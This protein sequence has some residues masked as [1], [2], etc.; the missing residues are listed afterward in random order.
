MIGPMH[1]KSGTDMGKYCS[2]YGI[3]YK[4]TVKEIEA[5]EAEIENALEN[6]EKTSTELVYDY[7]LSLEVVDE[8]IRNTVKKHVNVVAYIQTD[9]VDDHEKEEF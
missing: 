8:L 3:H 4:G 1:L 5:F 2:K 9:A 7:M 6:A